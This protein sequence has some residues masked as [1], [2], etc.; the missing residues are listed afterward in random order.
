MAAGAAGAGLAAG[1]ALL[2]SR[3]ASGRMARLMEALRE[4]RTGIWRWDIAED[5]IEWDAALAAV[6]GLPPDAAPRRVSDV[7]AL[8]HEEDRERI[9]AAVRR[10]IEKGGSAEY[11]FRI[12]T[13]SGEER[14]IHDRSR[15]VHDRTGRPLAMLG[16]CMDITA[17][18]QAE[19]HL[20]RSEQRY[21]SLVDATSTLAW[22]RD[23][24]GHF[25]EPQPAW[26]AYTGQGWEEYRGLGWLAA[27]HPEDRPVVRENWARAMREQPDL[28]ES[29]A[30]I[31]HAPSRS[32]HIFLTRAVSIRDPDGSV[33]EWAGFANDVTDRR[34]AQAALRD[35]EAR[36][37]RAAEAA[38]FATFEVANPDAEHIVS[39]SFR[40]LWGRPQGTRIDLISLLTR[41]HPDDRQA[42]E[43][44]RRGIATRGGPFEHE[45]RVV[46][47][48]GSIR[49]LQSRGEAEPGPDGLPGRVVGVNLDVTARKQAQRRQALLVRELNHRVKNMLATVQALSVQT[50]RSAEGDHA[51]FIQDFSARLQAL[52]RTHDL[53][54]ASAW[55]PTPLQAT[56]AAALAPWLGEQARIRL[57]CASG[58][59]LSPRQ[60]Q[61]LVLALNELAT[62]ATKHGS[63]SV[64]DGQVDLACTL[65]PAGSG[66]ATV[67]IEWRESGGPPVR[68]PARRGFG[69]RLLEQ[70]LVR[71]F[72]GEVRLDYL[73]TGLECRIR[74]P[75]VSAEEPE[76]AEPQA[77]TSG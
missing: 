8:V 7:L 14:W 64:P 6:F 47:P 31:W 73:P 24:A 16:V 33:R 42:F 37:R 60:A 12:R 51:R 19:L 41:V 9:G 70:G 61:A 25:T 72:G 3:R 26:E 62:N 44:H 23:G 21:R 2:R 43:A 66:A 68:P 71:E 40:E 76:G 48:D 20:Q 63:L 13:P 32:W 75:L 1:I 59:A 58:P 65:E 55:E 67:V 45:F 34:I 35:S 18:K 15:I 69:S 36:L 56:A 11:E 38:R 28:Y 30:R 49:W 50:R 77:L 39:E 46:L 54:T 4:S 22:R 17:R 57:D 53:L 52:A 74:L 10:C 5:R 29:E 27:I